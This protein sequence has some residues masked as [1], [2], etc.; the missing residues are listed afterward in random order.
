ML[1]GRQLRVLR[2]KFGLCPGRAATRDHVCLE[3]SRELLVNLPIGR[4]VGADVTEAALVALDDLLDTANLILRDQAL[5]PFVF[6]IRQGAN[7]IGG[8]AIALGL[9]FLEHLMT[10][11]NQDIRGS[12]R[13]REV[14]CTGAQGGSGL[15]SS[16]VELEHLEEFQGPTLQLARLGVGVL[17]QNL[18]QGLGIAE[19]RC[20]RLGEG[21][22]RFGGADR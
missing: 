22:N 6:R 8:F 2:R 15:G 1:Q 20:R 11:S 16:P 13:I 14:R 5:H 9:D 7:G 3:L 4:T 19:H 21:A 12:C 17:P 18:L 10:V